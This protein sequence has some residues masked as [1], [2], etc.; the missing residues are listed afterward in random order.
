MKLN[1]KHI[2][3]CCVITAIVGV[4]A[5]AL[6][7]TNSQNYNREMY[8]KAVENIQTERLEKLK[9]EACFETEHFIIRYC[10]SEVEPDTVSKIAEYAEAAY[11]P[12]KEKLQSQYQQKTNIVI[13]ELKA[14]MENA[15]NTA[16]YT[17]ASII[18]LPPVIKPTTEGTVI[19]EFTHVIVKDITSGDCPKWFNEG[20]AVLM[21]ESI[22][23]VVYGSNEAD[24]RLNKPYTLAELEDFESL[25]NK[26]LAYH[27]AS[28]IVRYI[29]A[30]HGKD[31]LLQ[32][33]ND[34]NCRNPD[35]PQIIKNRLD[36]DYKTFEQKA[37]EWA[38]EN[39]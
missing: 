22:L 37:L 25:Q 31:R 34:L 9:L 39:E 3:A 28:C 38:I 24:L 33:L 19:H 27:Q 29:V 13:K 32:I 35:F 10:P 2:A 1:I 12:V 8:L 20:I 5:A 26:A 17:S 4:T 7:G 14:V 23:D 21:E 30:T 16:G 36:M 11:E 6:I 15:N 18:Y